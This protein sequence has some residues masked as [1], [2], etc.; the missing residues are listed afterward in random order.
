[1]KAV[2]LAQARRKSESADSSAVATAMEAYEDAATRITLVA[3][4]NVNNALANRYQFVVDTANGSLEGKWVD[5]AREA[6]YIELISKM[7]TDMT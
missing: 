1:M 2:Q 3:S 5:T 6:T 4:E 7:R